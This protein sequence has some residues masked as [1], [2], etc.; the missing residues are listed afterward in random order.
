MNKYKDKPGNGDYSFG[1]IT[2]MLGIVFLL[3]ALSEMYPS[4]F[5][6][7]PYWGSSGTM[8]GIYIFIMIICFAF[9]IRFF[10]IGR[11]KNKEGN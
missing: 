3:S 7:V 10:I 11:C 9:S 2:A 1:F 8:I 6:W 4:I 5:F